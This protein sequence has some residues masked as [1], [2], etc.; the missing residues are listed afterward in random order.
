MSEFPNSDRTTVWLIETVWMTISGKLLESSFCSIFFHLLRTPFDWVREVSC[1]VLCYYLVTLCEFCFSINVNC[2]NSPITFLYPCLNDCL[3]N[4]WF[5]NLF[6][7][8]SGYDTA[9]RTIVIRKLTKM[10]PAWY[11][12]YTV[13]RSKKNKWC[14]TVAKTID[15]WQAREVGMESR[16]ANF[17]GSSACVLQALVSF[18]F[19]RLNIMTKLSFILQSSTK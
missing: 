15:I 7:K 18:Q 16:R 3:L 11:G 2:R 5:E 14:I 4:T 9:S 19:R 1:Y 8:G 10:T 13:S 17:F 6:T 12:F